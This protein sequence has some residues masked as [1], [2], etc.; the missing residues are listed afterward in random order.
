MSVSE[1]NEPSILNYAWG[2]QTSEITKSE[3][4]KEIKN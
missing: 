4:N 3:I 2:N 1:L